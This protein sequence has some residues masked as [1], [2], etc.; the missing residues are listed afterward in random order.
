MTISIVAK[1]ICQNPT[2]IPDFK[3]PLRKLGIYENFFNLIK[4]IQEKPTPSIIINGLRPN[5]FPRRKGTRQRCLPSPLPSALQW[6]VD[7]R[8]MGKGKERN[9]IQTR[10]E[11]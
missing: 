2:F 11:V 7:Y 3:N 8:T 1:S 5:A 10:K 4:G 9:G 6:R